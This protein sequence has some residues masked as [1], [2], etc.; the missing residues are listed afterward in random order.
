MSVVF[1]SDLGSS[2]YVRHKQLSM[3]M[4]NFTAA[5]LTERQQNVEWTFSLMT[6]K[7]LDKTSSF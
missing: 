5:N 4:Q 3:K 7:W 1:K 6:I 2:E